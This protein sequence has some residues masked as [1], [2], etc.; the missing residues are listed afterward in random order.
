[1]EFKFNNSKF[2]DWLLAK[3]APS[4]MLLL[5]RAIIGV[6]WLTSVGLLVLGLASVYK[7]DYLIGILYFLLMVLANPFDLKIQVEVKTKKD[8]PSDDSKR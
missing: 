6:F 1:M 8:L 4:R 7:G 2:L 3:G 5:K